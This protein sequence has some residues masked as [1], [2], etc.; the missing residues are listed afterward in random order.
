[1]PDP[2][3][4]TGSAGSPP[5]AA[6]R[7]PPPDPDISSLSERHRHVLRALGRERRTHMALLILGCRR[8]GD[9]DD[10]VYDM[11]TRGYAEASDDCM[12]WLTP[13]GREALAA[14]EREREREGES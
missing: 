2:S 9:A 5:A 12:I 6:A 7:V 13:A 1:M 8:S 11:I 14:I 10:P 3:S 4:S